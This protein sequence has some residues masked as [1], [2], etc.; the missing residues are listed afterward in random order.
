MKSLRQAMHRRPLLDPDEWVDE[1]VLKAP[2]ELL[3]ARVAG[4][5][6][7]VRVDGA[8][9]RAIQA[10]LCGLFDGLRDES[11]RQAVEELQNG[12]PLRPVTYVG[13]AGEDGRVR[14]AAPDGQERIARL[15]HGKPSDLDIGQTVLVD[16]T[17]ALVL[18]TNTGSAAPSEG[19]VA[20]F[21]RWIGD[22]LLVQVRDEW[23]VLNCT[24]GVRTAPLLSRGDRVFFCPV[25]RMCWGV[26]PRYDARDRFVPASDVADVG[27]K[28]IGN[29]HWILRFLLR[30]TDLL[31]FRPALLERFHLRRGIT[32][33]ATGP[34]GV[35]KSLTIR[36]FI[37]E[38]FL[39]LQRRVGGRDVGTRTIKINASDLLSPWF[40]QSESK[41]ENLFAETIRLA[42]E[43]VQTPDGEQE[44]P[45]VLILE[46]FEGLAKRRGED[47]NGA[48]DR[49]MGTLL[50]QFDNIGNLPVVCITSTNR[51]DLL[52]ASMAR[53]LGGTV[54][55]FGRLN[56][57]AAMAAVLSKKIK[58]SMLPGPAE[59]SRCRELVAS[60]TASFFLPPHAPD[61]GPVV[62]IVIHDGHGKKT[63]QKFDRDFLTGGIIEAGVSKAIDKVLLELPD[64]GDDT[65]GLTYTGVVTALRASVDGILDQL[66]PANVADYVELPREV[67]RQILSIRRLPRP[68]IPPPADA[69]SVNQDEV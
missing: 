31:L 10:W 52:D 21:E 36:A 34:T 47:V 32:V 8:D 11:A 58:P 57:R 6:S 50:Q 66:T 7:E 29:P 13:P 22:R 44:L 48:Y 20:T 35:G 41:I 4:K 9:A 27:I 46:E 18:H 25:R 69:E 19:V 68:A 54:A 40:G 55:H 63:L 42:R 51:P 56:T 14:I 5:L 16:S 53:R 37:H 26:L 33:L 43:K 24:D 65:I 12:V 62:E 39:L 17:G 28:D 23:L 15:A 38:F 61:P 45:V 59:E 49:V 3:A 64:S 30:R 67:H 2:S 60:V 1:E